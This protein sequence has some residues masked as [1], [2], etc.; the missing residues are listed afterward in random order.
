[1]ADQLFT[2]LEL[3]KRSLDAYSLRQRVI[4]ENIANAET[5]GYKSRSVEFEALLQAALGEVQAG[6][7][8]QSEPGHMQASAAALPEAG[9]RADSELA[10][11]NGINDVSLDLEM[12][13]LAET[14]LRHKL[15]AR[16]LALRYKGLRGAIRGSGQP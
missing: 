5:P 1:M 16:I 10:M 14:N 12:A 11:D 2:G 4:A 8:A 7:L 13:A 6:A 3:L 15:A 9:V